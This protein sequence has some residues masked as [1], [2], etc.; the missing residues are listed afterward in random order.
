MNID[1]LE[2]YQNDLIKSR[3]TPL[4]IEL[5]NKDLDLFQ[6]SN[7]LNKSDTKKIA[8]LL[9]KKVYDD[10]ITIKKT[11][12]LYIDTNSSNENA[13]IEKLMENII[14]LDKTVKNLELLKEFVTL[15]SNILL[16]N[17]CIENKYIEKGIDLLI[18]KNFDATFYKFK[19]IVINN[20]KKN[21]SYKNINLETSNINNKLFITTESFKKIKELLERIKEH[22][23]PAKSIQLI[24]NILIG[25]AIDEP[26]LIFIKDPEKL[27]RNSLT[28]IS[29]I[30]SYAKNLKIES[31][32]NIGI[33]FVFL[34]TNKN[35][36]ISYQFKENNEIEKLL[37]DL[38]LFAQRYS[39]LSRPTSKLPD[40]AVKAT[41]FIGRK[42]ELEEL[43]GSY[44]FSKENKNIDTFEILCAEPGIGK[45]KLIIKHLEDIKKLNI[46]E[47]FLQL[48]LLNQAGHN[49]T[50]TGISS[51]IHS[52]LEE[53]ERLYIE[54]TANE[55]LKYD[56]LIKGSID[57]VYDEIKSLLGI[58]KV[59]DF[60]KLSYNRLNINNIYDSFKSKARNYED[61]TTNTRIEQFRKIKESLSL[62]IDTYKINTPIVLF[63]DDLQWIDEDSAEFII[64]YLSN[65]F[66]LHIVASLRPSDANTIIVKNSENYLLNKYK[67]ALLKNVKIF[68]EELNKNVE[69]GKDIDCDIDISHLKINSTYLKG[70]D[71]KTLKE[72][73][74]DLIDGTEEQYE[75]FTKTII[76][77]LLLKQ[78]DDIK[79]ETV[80]TLFAIEMINLFCD[81]Y[82]YKKNNLN[83]FIINDNGYK[84]NNNLEFLS[85]LNQSFDFL[86]KE[87]YK[88]S[89]SYYSSSQN[90]NSVDKYTLA[91]YAVIE[92]RLNILK[93]YFQEYGNASVNTLLFASLICE[94]FD[95]QLVKK[96]LY[97]LSI[98]EEEELLPI[99]NYLNNSKQYFIEDIHYEI[100]EEVYEI[101]SRCKSFNNSYN[102]NHNLFE[103]FLNNKMNYMLDNILGQNNTISKDIF[104]TKILNVT[105]DYIKEYDFIN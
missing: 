15:G 62:L 87:E 3:Y 84:F 59:I 27:D 52:I 47:N 45:T 80:N 44:K 61:K 104:Y 14:D 86:Y 83:K 91:S 16:K 89:F 22:S 98:A 79:Y 74:S 103:I 94:P 9:A 63:I 93:I 66:N 19:N 92:E 8:Y 90:T 82:F 1:I 46:N 58:D 60:G 54:K 29:M 97:Q 73:I 10:N 65:S 38:S 21:T 78:T 102:Y 67:I 42:K 11:N 57:T 56:D 81:E 7:D 100:L 95:S 96:I 101:V 13:L 77:C 39:M 26:K 36:E 6:S 18:D 48:T 30:L 31:E 37:H 34:Y 88:Q 75:I 24:V 40:V 20:S 28:I 5:T 85:T 105:Y 69:L 72:L 35:N 49:S 12:I 2:N 99:R 76:K 41:K 17:F 53:T 70:F 51:L 71:Y 43:M 33:S 64:K 4:L 68:K 55:L 50:N 23:S 25:I 32:K